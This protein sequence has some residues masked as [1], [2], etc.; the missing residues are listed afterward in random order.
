MRYFTIIQRRF[1]SF[2]GYVMKLTNTFKHSKSIDARPH[3][4]LQMSNSMLAI[5]VL[6]KIVH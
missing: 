4:P 6:K 1:D 2:Q 5:F 3:S